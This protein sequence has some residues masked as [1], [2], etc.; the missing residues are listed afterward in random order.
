MPDAPAPTTAIFCGSSSNAHASSVPT[1]RPPNSVP[2]IGFGIE[3]VARI[4]HFVASISV[5]SKLPPTFTL[6]SLVSDPKPSMYS[7]LFLRNSPDTPPVSVEI[8]LR[9]RSPTL[10]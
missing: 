7:T 1:M 2:G 6:P 3:P 5:P 4:T 8:T 9:R 10:S